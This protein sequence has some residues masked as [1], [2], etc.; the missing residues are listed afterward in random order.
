DTAQ[1]SNVSITN[2]ILSISGTSTMHPYTVSTKTLKVVGGIA[3]S[4]N[5]K[6]LLQPGMLQGLELQIPVNSFTSD[7]DGLAKQMAKALK[8]DKHPGITFKLN[9]Y[10]V[11]PAAAGVALKPNGTLTAAGG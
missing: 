4:A 5:L 3:T 10:T 8:A 9:G 11:E 2:A 6:E 7:K 1:G